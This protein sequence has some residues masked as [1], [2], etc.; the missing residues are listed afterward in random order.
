M[1]DI[2]MN[3]CSICGNMFPDFGAGEPDDLIE[4]EFTDN[5]YCESC[6]T[7]DKAIKI[8]EKARKKNLKFFSKGVST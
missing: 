8:E 6:L 2:P 7:S 5:L 1:N 3:Q 4:A